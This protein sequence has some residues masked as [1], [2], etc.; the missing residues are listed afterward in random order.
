MT[1]LL[2]LAALQ[3]NDLAEEPKPR[4]G[5]FLSL[6]IEEWWAELSGNG[7]DGDLRRDLEISSGSAETYAI[8]LGVA[9]PNGRMDHI[10]LRYWRGR[11]S[12]SG[13]LS[14]DFI[15]D[16]E[17]FPA[18][19]PVTG[20]VEVDRYMF[21]W[22]FDIPLDRDQQFRLQLGPSFGV[23]RS[24]IGLSKPGHFESLTMYEIPIGVGI[25]FEWHPV[26]FAY[27]GTRLYADAG[28]LIYYSYEAQVEVGVR[29]GFATLEA[30][31]RIQRL[32]HLDLD[33]HLGGMFLGL[34]ADF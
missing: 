8:A 29:W 30:G 32:F 22:D 3:S 7:E 15:F 17:R 28:I 16:N 33:G 9:H 34:R 13:V 1:L 26:R 19:T 5:P 25:G 23:I 12:G 2:A 24:E 6:K 18:G 21:D 4:V 27:V 14:R 31:Y 10:G 11:W 20:R